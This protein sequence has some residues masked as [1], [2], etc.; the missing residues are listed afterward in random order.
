M[1][2]MPYDKKLVCPKETETVITNVGG[3]EVKAKIENGMPPS[4]AHRI[5]WYLRERGISQRELAERMGT[6]SQGQISHCLLGR[7]T[8]TRERVDEIC[9]ALEITYE[10]LM[11][12]EIAEPMVNTCSDPETVEAEVNTCSEEIAEAAVEEVEETVEESEEESEEGKIDIYHEEFDEEV[13]ATVNIAP[14]VEEEPT[15]SQEMYVALCKQI[16]ESLKRKSMADPYIRDGYFMRK[17]DTQSHPHQRLVDELKKAAETIIKNAESM[18]GTEK[19]LGDVMITIHLKQ[20]EVPR[21]NVDK[22]VYP[23]W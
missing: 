23:E 19:R 9:K 21:I 11:G 4:V 5:R 20:H 7:Y 18:I 12:E 15:I 17:E 10:E 22:D 6:I 3:E 14:M 13:S 16:E 8:L 1:Y 2:L